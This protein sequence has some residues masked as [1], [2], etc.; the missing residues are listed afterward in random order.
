MFIAIACLCFGWFARQPNRQ[1]AGVDPEIKN[2]G[3]VSAS[4]RGAAIDIRSV[5]PDLDIR[6]LD[7]GNAQPGKRV[8]EVV[9]EFANTDVYH[10]TYL[11]LDWQ[12]DKSYP[13]IFE[14]AGNGGYK[15]KYGDECTGLAEDCKLGYGISGGRGYIWVC[16]P[17]LNHAGNSNSA[18]WWG[19]RSSYDPQP[20]VEYCKKAVPLI[21]EKYGGDP[22]RV[23]LAGFSRGAIACNFI[24]LHDDEISKLWKGFIPYSHYDGAANFGLPGTDR[25]SAL[26]RLKRLGNRPQFI[27]AEAGPGRH[28]VEASKAYLDSTGVNGRFTFRETGFRNHNDSWI[29][30][31]SPARDELRNWVQA[32]LK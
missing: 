1:P 7:T 16:L 29:L 5:E 23:L 8:K 12:P 31:P 24:G 15:N 19:D 28:T 14:F 17:F 22:E 9:P 26:S 20:T 13:V 32:T 3:D 4:L 2:T 25:N 18:M 27:C 30:R 6:K 21:C 11:P 10:V